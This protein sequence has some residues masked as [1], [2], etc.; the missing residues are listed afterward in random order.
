[1]G[2]SRGG[3]RREGERL[4]REAEQLLRRR[5]EEEEDLN[6]VRKR[7]EE[8]HVSSAEGNLGEPVSLG[9]RAGGG[10][11]GRNSKV[12]GSEFRSGSGSGVRCGE[13]RRNSEPTSRVEERGLSR[14]VR[15][16]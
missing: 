6:W 7:M 13:G 8:V 2:E 4:V 15:N 16:L 9:V 3:V 1:M 11:I 14:A 12:S 10:N 5:V